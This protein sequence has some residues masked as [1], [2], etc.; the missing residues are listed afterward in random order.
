M[1]AKDEVASIAIISNEMLLATIKN[2][3]DELEKIV[4][5][6]CIGNVDK[7]RQ[8][9]ASK[10]T[11]FSEK[12]DF[13][14]KE[15]NAMDLDDDIKDSFLNKLDQ[16]AEA[17]KTLQQGEDE[18]LR[19]FKG[20]GLSRNDKTKIMKSIAA[21]KSSLSDPYAQTLSAAAYSTVMQGLREHDLTDYVTV[22][23]LQNG[24]YIM[25]YN[26]YYKKEIENV[27]I[28]KAYML[29]D[30]H[31]ATPEDIEISA[32]SSAK[33]KANAALLKYSGLSPE[34]AEKVMEESERKGIVNFSKIENGDGTYTVLCSAGEGQNERNKIYKEA[35]KIILKAAFSMTGDIGNIEKKRMAHMSNEYQKIDNILDAV[36]NWDDS[37]DTSGYIYSIHTQDKKVVIDDRIEFNEE[38]FTTYH[39]N[40]SD[41]TRYA[42]KRNPHNYKRILRY[43]IFSGT[44]QKVY[45]SN[46]EMEKLKNDAQTM[47]PMVNQVIETSGS[48]KTAAM[49]TF[50]DKYNEA[51]D[52]LSQAYKD[53]NE[54]LQI[55]YKQEK[56]KYKI[57]MEI[58]ENMKPQN[59][60]SQIIT[61][62]ACLDRV[63]A[64][65]LSKHQFMMYA[66]KEQAFKV[67]TERKFINWAIQNI[68]DNGNLDFENNMESKYSSDIQEYEVDNLANAI[69]SVDVN[70]FIRSEYEKAEATTEE[71]QD[72]N[73]LT[74]E[75]VNN[76]AK[77][78][79]NAFNQQLGETKEILGKVRVYSED[80]GRT[81]L[82]IGTPYSEKAKMGAERYQE[83]NEHFHK[84]RAEKTEEKY[85]VQLPMV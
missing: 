69:S 75:D 42:D 49:A 22:G 64:N 47:L 26:S 81:L 51:D 33:N 12:I 36:E 2:L 65:A 76:E 85:Q 78:I 74:I 80:M 45:I 23:R 15:I 21:A 44:G 30:A 10:N 43:C 34:M 31:R 39:G 48:D 82:G 70:D 59:D 19:S 60:G 50:I 41:R 37:V 62:E 17:G 66:D 6:N 68:D 67:N 16:I 54:T 27:L 73:V 61:Q 3:I 13:I 4:N 55:A 24:K 46:D 20:S 11:P 7:C 58:I 56:D 72:D 1:M 8:S 77:I 83:E 32:Y 40:A 5:E 71:S 57:A 18:V 35:N 14:K 29:G 63:I 53:K 38:K 25:F 9:I 52:N 28:E 79:E 84:E